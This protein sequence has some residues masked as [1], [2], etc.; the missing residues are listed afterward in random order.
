MIYPIAS[1]WQEWWTNIKATTIMYLDDQYL[2]ATMMRQ[3]GMDNYLRLDY[4]IPSLVICRFFAT[5]KYIC[6]SIPCAYYGLFRI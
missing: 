4:I 1:F 2:K 5:K 6:L 3:Q